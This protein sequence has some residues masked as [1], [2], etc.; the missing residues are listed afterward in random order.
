M[1]LKIVVPQIIHFNGIFHYKLATPHFRNPPCL[2]QEV[3]I[4]R[5][6]FDEDLLLTIERSAAQF[7]SFSL[8]EDGEAT[9]DTGRTRAIPCSTLWYC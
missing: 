6:H 7:E 2:L 5:S 1:F 3:L 8:P 4:D 9:E